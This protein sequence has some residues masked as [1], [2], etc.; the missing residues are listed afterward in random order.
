MLRFVRPLRGIRM[1]WIDAL[2]ID[3]SNAKER[4][5]QVSN[6]GD[7]YRNSLRTIAYLGADIV[8]PLLDRYPYRMD[9]EKLL[10]REVRPRVS[11][12]HPS[13]DSADLLK[14][15]LSRRYFSRVWVIQ[16][17]ILSRQ[18][19]FRIGDVEFTTNASTWKTRNATG[20]GLQRYL[21]P[22]PWVQYMGQQSFS[23]FDMFDMIGLTSKSQATDLRDRLFGVLSL[24][25]EHT[26]SSVFIPNYSLSTVHVFLGFFAHCLVNLERTHLFHHAAGLSSSPTWLPNWETQ[27]SWEKIFSQWPLQFSAPHLYGLHAEQSTLKYSEFPSSPV[28]RYEN[29]HSHR[30]WNQDA[31]IDRNTGAMT[32]FLIKFCTLPARPEPVQYDVFGTRY[33]T[34]LG[35]NSA[36]CLVSA[37]DL[38]AETI[39]PRRDFIFIVSDKDSTCLVLREQPSSG[40]IMQ[41]KLITTLSRLYIGATQRRAFGGYSGLDLSDL[42]QSVFEHVTK[43]RL[44]LDQYIY[45]TPEGYPLCRYFP[46]TER[47]SILYPLFRA[48]ET[49]DSDDSDHYTNA[50][51]LAMRQIMPHADIQIQNCYI[52]YSLSAR[53]WEAQLPYDWPLDHREKPPQLSH[54]YHHNV[55]PGLLGGCRWLGDR[56]QWLDEGKWTNLLEQDIEGKCSL[57]LQQKGHIEIRLP[58]DG[59]PKAFRFLPALERIRSNIQMIGKV[60]KMNHDEVIALLYSVPED[61][62]KLIGCP[63]AFGGLKEDFGVDG[64]TVQVQI[65]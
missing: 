53:D 44:S 17:L 57:T 23:V 21:T 9:F 65:V 39:Q 60:M 25:D 32:L 56:G 48:L 2:C 3:Q 42:Q 22:A 41:Y 61:D 62:L 45:A 19:I 6:M 24:L 51:V 55:E 46:G 8:L 26:Q 16:E 54:I 10:E 34:F 29:K 58:L 4:G 37:T 36:L 52:R 13:H 14:Y 64:S 33:F 27:G 31:V 15:I 11:D 40:P 49:S 50:C 5:E 30:R 47:L 20:Q 38:G 35:S 12:S 18:T 1:V 7:I 28:L 59:L 63:L 43:T